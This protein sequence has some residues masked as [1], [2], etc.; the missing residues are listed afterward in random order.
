MMKSEP[1]KKKNGGSNLDTGNK[2]INTLYWSV[3]NS[4]PKN[5]DRCREDDCSI[6]V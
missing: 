6:V 1:K 5:N 2:M 3:E 4:I